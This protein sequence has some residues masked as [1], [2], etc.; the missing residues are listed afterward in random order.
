[1]KIEYSLILKV[2]YHYSSK[3]WLKSLE[4]GNDNNILFKWT[5]I[6]YYIN[7]WHARKTLS[8]IYDG[9]KWKLKNISNTVC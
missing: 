4:K 1:M 2:K 6:E 3:F 9:R 8:Q 7:I 5:M